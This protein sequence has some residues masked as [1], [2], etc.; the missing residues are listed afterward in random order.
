MTAGSLI[1]ELV[2]FISH[3]HALPSALVGAHEKSFD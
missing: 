2:C 3:L 1:S